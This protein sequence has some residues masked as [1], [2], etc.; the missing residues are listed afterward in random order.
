MTRLK[1]KAFTLIEIIIVV[2]IIGVLASTA[3]PKLANQVSVAKAAEAYSILGTLMRKIMECYTMAE[4][5]NQCDAVA[6]LPSFA[7]PSSANFVYSYV[8]GASATSATGTASLGGST[9]DVITFT[10]NVTNGSVNK[11]KGGIFSNLKQ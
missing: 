5:M 8:A 2:I 1:T 3:L 11:L 10:I 7:F 6:K 4:N 9:A